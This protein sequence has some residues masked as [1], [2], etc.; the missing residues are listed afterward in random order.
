MQVDSAGADMASRRIPGLDRGPH[1]I[2]APARVPV[3]GRTP[4][5]DRIPGRGRV[6]IPVRVRVQGQV[7]GRIQG[8]A[9]DQGRIPRVHRHHHRRLPTGT[10]RSGMRPRSVPAS[11]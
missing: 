4:I 9:R 5:P 3:R 11:Q 10:I 8:L 7:Q 6:L 1:R 2:R